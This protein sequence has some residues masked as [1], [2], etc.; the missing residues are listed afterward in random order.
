MKKIKAKFHLPKAGK[1]AALGVALDDHV[2]SYVE[3]IASPHGLS[4]TR[5][6][7]VPLETDSGDSENRTIEL[8]RIFEGLKRR[9]KT[10]SLQIA[11]PD[12]TATFFEMNVPE[13]DPFLLEHMVEREVKKAVG[14]THSFVLQTEI[15]YKEKNNTKVAV[16]MLPQGPIDRM[17]ALAKTAGFR[18]DYVGLTTEVVAELIGAD[19]TSSIIISVKARET[20]ITILSKGSL[21]LEEEVPTG[22]EIWIEKIAEHFEIDREAATEALFFE[23]LP[24][25]TANGMLALLRSELRKI[26]EAAEKVFLYWHV[27]CRKEKECR[28]HQVTLIGA[29]ASIPGLSTL[30]ESALHVETRTPEPFKG[31]KLLNDIP[32]MTEAESLKYLPA[33]ALALK[34]LQE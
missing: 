34:G 24:T 14:D 32:E 7:E 18:L 8:T 6:G 23:G 26:T 27:D 17:K 30:L 13:S 15:L 16:T 25:T 19:E 4:V 9:A 33:L 2:I 3:A 29:G 20:S 12:G 28:V 31:I 5:F 10:K 22:T 11:I 1:K 21:V